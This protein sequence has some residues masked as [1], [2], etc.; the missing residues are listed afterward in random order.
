[1]NASFG[2]E[3]ITE[4]STQSADQKADDDWVRLTSTDGFS[5]MV[6]R[7]VATASGTLKSMLSAESE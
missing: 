4:I 6:K 5:F 3:F 1:L 2:I 7:K